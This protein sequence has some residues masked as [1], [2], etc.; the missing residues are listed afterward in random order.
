MLVIC[1]L[2]NH[3]TYRE[4]VLF[5]YDYGQQPRYHDNYYAY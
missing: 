5:W 4:E 3:L 2:V 1:S